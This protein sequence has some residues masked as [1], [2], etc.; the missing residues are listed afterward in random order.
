MSAPL[1]FKDVQINSTELLGSSKLNYIVYEVNNVKPNAKI[2][3]SLRK[4]ETISQFGD[5]CAL[6]LIIY[7][8]NEFNN[9]IWYNHSCNSIGIVEQPI[10]FK[11]IKRL[12][13]QFNIRERT[14]LT[15]D[16][17]ISLNNVLVDVNITTSNTSNLFKI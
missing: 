2:S 11:D 10:E 8:V 3:C 7:G 16:S 5:S 6:K 13:L 1:N 9:L 4:F 12:F 17:M 15:I 14:D